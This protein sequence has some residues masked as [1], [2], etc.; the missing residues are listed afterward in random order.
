MRSL[1]LIFVVGGF[2]FAALLHFDASTANS[3]PLYAKEFRVHYLKA[4]STNADENSLDDAVKVAS[5]NVCHVNGKS[6]STR[7]AY[8]MELAKLLRPKDAPADFKGE[9]DHSKIDEAFEKVSEMHIDAND[10]KSPTYGDL[11]KHGKLPASASKPSGTSDKKS[12]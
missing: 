5:C 9:I 4:D 2:A 8:G 7:N 6:K 12:P 3:R 1:S 11:I 10:S